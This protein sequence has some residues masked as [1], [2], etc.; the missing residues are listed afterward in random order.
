MCHANGNECE[1]PSK[2]DPPI[3]VLVDNLDD[4][5]NV[6]AVLYKDLVSVDNFKNI[7]VIVSSIYKQTDGPNLQKAIFGVGPNCPNCPTSPLNTILYTLKKPYIFGISLDKNYFGGVSLGLIDPLLYTASINYT[8]MGKNDALYSISPLVMESYWNGETLNI[9][10]TDIPRVIMKT[11]SPLSYL[12]TPAFQKFRTFLRVACKNDVD[13]CSRIDTLF[14]SCLPTNISQIEKFPSFD[15]R[16]DEGFYIAFKPSTYFY[17]VSKEGQIFQC[18]GVQETHESYAV[19]GINL[20]REPVGAV[21]LSQYTKIY[22]DDK[23]KKHYFYIVNENDKNQR[24]FHLISE[25]ADEM[26]EWIT[27]ITGFFEGDVDDLKSLLVGVKE[28]KDKTQS[29]IGFQAS[30][31]QVEVRDDKADDYKLDNFKLVFKGERVSLM[32]QDENGS[33]ASPRAQKQVSPN[34]SDATNDGCELSAL[35][36]QLAAA[37]LEDGGDDDDSNDSK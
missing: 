21:D 12:P 23:T 6:R 4:G 20:M 28:K 36:D 32:L 15:L 30:E 5:A 2:N 31:E 26:L 18:I 24:V 14:T 7:P 27:I 37:D 17:S 35:R 1:R 33:P 25:S 10:R 11:V 16:F 22:K 13:L 19:F 3:C 8:A 29:S 9:S 34:T